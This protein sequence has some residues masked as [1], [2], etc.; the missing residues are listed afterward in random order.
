MALASSAASVIKVERSLHEVFFD[1]FEITDEIRR[2]KAPSPTCLGY[3]N[4]LISV[5]ATQSYEVHPPGLNIPHL[6]PP[7]AYASCVLLCAGTISSD[8]T[9][10]LD[11]RRCGVEN[12]FTIEAR[13]P[14]LR[15]G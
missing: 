14:V 6:W 1:K 13:Q 5:A 11:I 3:S 9:V 7:V 15:V 10:F 12:E 2:S 8:P 4:H